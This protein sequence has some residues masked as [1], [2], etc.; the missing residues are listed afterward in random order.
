MSRQPGWVLRGRCPGWALLAAFSIWPLLGLSF[1]PLAAGAQGFSPG[2]GV[3]LTA[4]GTAGGSGFQAV[5]SVGQPLLGVATAGSWTFWAGILSPP[6]PT[7]VIE[8]VPVIPVAAREGEPAAI[9][10]EVTANRP[11]T[12]VRLHYRQGGQT[13]YSYLPMTARGERTWAADV[14]GSSVNLRGLEHYLEVEAGG[15]TVDSPTDDP[16]ANPYRLSVGVTG[17]DGGGRLSTTARR[18]RMFS[19]PAVLVDG[20]PTA[21]LTDDLGQPDSS[22]WRC[23]RW[24]NAAEAYREVGLDSVD[25][26][27]PG[28]AYWLIT[29]QPRRV[30]FSGATA[31][32][33]DSRGRAITL[34][35][36]WNQIGNPFAYEVQLAD[37]LIDDGSRIRSFEE[38]VANGLVEARPLHEYDGATY[39]ADGTSLSP[40]TGYFVANLHDTDIDLVL[41]AREASAI[42]A[43]RLFAG[44]PL[45]EQPLVPS[46]VEMPDWLLTLHARSAGGVGAVE[47]GGAA[48][49]AEGWDRWDRLQPPAAPR[50]GAVLRLYNPLMPAR[51]QALQRD[52]RPLDGT[53]GGGT[54]MVQALASQAG[55]VQLTWQVPA[56]LPAGYSARLVDLQRNTWIALASEGA[57][58]VAFGHPGTASFRVA[59][60]TAGWLDLQSGAANPAGA[61]FTASL[62]GSNP[63]QGALQVRLELD[64]AQHAVAQVF[65]VR[66]RLVRKLVDEE[67]GPGV[68]V[69]SWDGRST[70]G[71]AASGLYFVRVTG[72]GNDRILRGVL[73]R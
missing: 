73:I 57:Y 5:S 52:V 61:H 26:F 18:Y 47:I 11:V 39:H 4:G 27:T 6:S 24:N 15:R 72:G 21:V 53:G 7:V 22:L 32:P 19:I 29:A 70:E 66:G 68:H 35:P 25:P 49:A 13:D 65:D 64:Q 44:H 60:G 23:G 38:A 16:T 51:T 20:L 63:G 8:I 58:D 43:P 56:N 71:E 2:A 45:G 69:L 9:E 48:E 55:I 40:W 34:K 36:G 46:R 33:L 41:P 31:F 37:A 3:C 62:V 1:L 30:T 12:S 17:A 14:P 10:Y 42:A 59:V 54:W 67:M 50:S 28:R